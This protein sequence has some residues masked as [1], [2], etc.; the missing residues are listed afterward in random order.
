MASVISSEHV[1]NPSSTLPALHPTAGTADKGGH[2]LG[3]PHP[4]RTLR[5]AEL[6]GD[7]AAARPGSPS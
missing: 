7:R 5:G 1:H 2:G 6:Q 4:E 3:L